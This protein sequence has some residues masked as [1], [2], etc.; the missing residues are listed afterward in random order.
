SG[1]VGG[2]KEICLFG[3][4][5]CRLGRQLVRPLLAVIL[6]GGRGIHLWTLLS[7]LS[8]LQRTSTLNLR[9][10]PRCG[11]SCAGDTLNLPRQQSE[12]RGIHLCDMP[13][14]RGV[15]FCAL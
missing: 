4:H 3:C 7:V 8:V 6:L 10:S 11:T 1:R 15:I 9:S 12:G 5:L 2:A 14:K 13:R